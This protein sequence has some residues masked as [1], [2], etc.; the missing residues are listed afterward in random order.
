MIPNNSHCPICIDKYNKTVHLRIQCNHCNYEACKSCYQQY[1][2]HNTFEPKCMNCFKIFTREELVQKFPK[3]WINTD[4]KQHREQLLFNQEKSMLPATQPQVEREIEKENI[5]QTLI[6]LREQVFQIK[7]TIRFYENKFNETSNSDKIERK[8]FVRK[9]PNP[10]CRGF[11]STQWKCNLCNQK[12]C[13]ECNECILS[14]DEHKC[15][16]NNVETVKLLEKDSKPCPRCGEIIF[17]IDGCDQMFCTQCHSA[18]SWRTGL[19]DNGIIHNPHYFEWSRLNNRQIERNGVQVHCGREIDH[20]FVRNARSKNASTDFLKLCRNLIHF[21]YVELR[22]FHTDQFQNNQDLR[23][24]YLRG[25]ITE[26]VFRNMVQKRDKAFQKNTDLY[27]LF[28]MMIQCM[29]EIM[30]RYY[31]ELDTKQNRVCSSFVFDTNISSTYKPYEKE[32]ITLIDY[33]NDCLKNI[34]TTYNS[35]RYIVYPNLELRSYNYEDK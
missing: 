29:T 35:K 20:E 13:K 6:A 15:D 16:P 26:Q 28:T 10:N 14:T 1:I 24:A 5:Q 33:I 32:F 25:K 22:R 8:V 21:R 9:C 11:L 18:F 2:I 3:K 12:T 30:Y 31:E 27:R 19:I 7:N 23:I 34:S 17:K 4:Y